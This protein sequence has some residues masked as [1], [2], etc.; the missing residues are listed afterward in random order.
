[1]KDSER[2]IMFYFLK[3]ISVFM[4]KQE[5]RQSK[6]SMLAG[7]EKSGMF[8]GKEKRACTLASLR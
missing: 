4:R 5:I 1:M 6:I 2:N 7:K 3:Q 8:A